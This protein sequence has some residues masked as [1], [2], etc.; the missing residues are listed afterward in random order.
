MTAPF[1]PGS[2]AVM[3]GRGTRAPAGPPGPLATRDPDLAAMLREVL[4]D[5][6]QLTKANIA[7]RR[8]LGYLLGHPDPVVVAA[9]EEALG[10]YG[11]DRPEPLAAEPAPVQPRTRTV[12]WPWP[13]RRA[14]A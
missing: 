8:T 2:P 5:N 9:T 7:H 10:R 4:E 1:R 12:A 6:A 3:P 11:A 13:F 14:G